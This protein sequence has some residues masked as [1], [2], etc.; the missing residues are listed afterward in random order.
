M[1]SG[2][3]APGAHKAVFDASD[4]F[5]TDIWPDTGD[6]TG[7]I[8]SSPSAG[9]LTDSTYTPLAGPIEEVT[10][11]LT[12]TLDESNYGIAIASREVPGAHAPGLR[13]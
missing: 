9:M 6:M 10:N 7:P 8:V 2:T 12:P 1:P 11:F 13:A 3:L 4:G 5:D